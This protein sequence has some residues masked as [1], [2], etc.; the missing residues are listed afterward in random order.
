MKKILVLGG[1]GAMGV[2][3]VNILAK[4]NEVYVTSRRFIESNGNIHYKTGNALNKEFLTE[5]LKNHLWDAV[6]DFMAR[7]KENLTETLPLFLKSTEQYVFISSAR[8]YAESEVPITEDTPRLLDVSTDKEFLKTNEYAL[9]KAQEEDILFN[10]DCKNF[11]IIRPSITYND[12]RL[13]LGVFEKEEWLNRALNGHTIVFSRDL[14]DKTTTMTHGD[15]VAAGIAALIGKKDAIGKA[16]H[17]TSP[18]SL[19]WREVLNIYKETLE[20]ELGKEI[21]IKLTEKSTNF[22]FPEKKY[23]LIYCR[24]FNRSFDNT[25]ISKFIDVDKFKTPEEGLRDC[26]KQCMTNPQFLYKNL[27]LEAEHDRISGEFTP[28]SSI[29]GM[30]KKFKYLLVRYNLHT[31]HKLLL[32]LKK[33]LE[34]SNTQPH[35][36]LL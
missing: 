12:Q 36:H 32:W 4:D 31:L 25:R 14:M 27:D 13:Q 28:L 16:F 21:K 34:T 35:I 26:L 1:T 2:P 22:I 7:T 24:Y 5:L 17:I 20:K 3:L 18:R 6:I 33:L 15:D 11:T 29:R 30:H 23:Q 19:K 10:S 8:V 9:A